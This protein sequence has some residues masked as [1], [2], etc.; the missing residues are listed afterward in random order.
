MTGKELKEARRK[1]GIYQYQLAVCLDTP[2]RTLQDWENG[3]NTIPG[4]M[5]VLMGLLVERDEKFMQSVADRLKRKV[6]VG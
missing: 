5:A 3:I 2:V 1:I 4:H 6:T